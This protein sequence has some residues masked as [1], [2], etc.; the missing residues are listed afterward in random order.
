MA[1][2]KDL[3]IYTEVSTSAD[4][5]H[6]VQS[7]ALANSLDDVVDILTPCSIP[8]GSRKDYAYVTADRADAH[9]FAHQ[10]NGKVY[11]RTHKIAGVTVTIWI[12][13]DQ[14]TPGDLDQYYP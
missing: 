10:Y 11:R 4:R 3:F 6:Q 5:L 12:C 14:G 1:R 2:P 7:T 13:V 9:R 8:A